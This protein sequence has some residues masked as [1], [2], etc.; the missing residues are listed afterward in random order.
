MSVLQ[1]CGDGQVLGGRSPLADTMC[2]DRAVDQ[3]RGRTTAQRGLLTPGS[4]RIAQL[5]RLS[6]TPG[7]DQGCGVGGRG[8]NLGLREPPRV[9]GEGRVDV[10]GGVFV[11]V[12]GPSSR[13]AEGAP[14]RMDGGIIVSCPEVCEGDLSKHS[15]GENGVTAR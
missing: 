5:Y 15:R 4:H 12:I 3:E 1:S 2:S 7:V 8:I 11:E 13:E 6:R 9:D 14:A 10:G